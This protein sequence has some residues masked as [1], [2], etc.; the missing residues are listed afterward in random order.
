MRFPT[1]YNDQVVFSY[2]GDLYTVSKSGGT[3][4]KL[5]SDVG[6]CR[7]SP[8]SRR[9]ERPLHLPVSMMETQKFIL[10]LQKVVH[11]KG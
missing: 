1:I 9:M 11:L 2:A 7:C 3:A 8:N 6:Y 4:R 10:Y 5:T